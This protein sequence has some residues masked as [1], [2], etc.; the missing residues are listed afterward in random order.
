M[1][2]FLFLKS[3]PYVDRIG[4]VAFAMLMVIIIN[5]YVALSNLNTDFRYIIAVNLGA[6][7]TWGVI[8]GLIY[9]ISSSMERN[10]LRNKLLRLKTAA[11]GQTMLT[12]VKESLKDTFLESFDEKG[13][14]AIAKEI[15]THVPN[16]ALSKSK[17]LTRQE[18]MGWLSIIAIYLAVG[19]LLA[20]PF[21]LLRDKVVSWFISNT[22]GVSWLFWY[23]YQLG[24]S[25]GRNRWLLGA[26]MASVSIVF[27]AFSYA[28]YAL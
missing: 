6:C 2:V 24:E 13:K 14:E 11:K 8:D 10:L 19:L 28:A 23:G 27:L 26:L 17:V 20:V 4:E 22:V 18:L 21:V 9:A 25:V 5:G 15:I 3:L 1:A 12:Q 7:L 16:A